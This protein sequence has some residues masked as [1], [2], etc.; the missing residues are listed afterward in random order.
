MNLKKVILLIAV[1]ALLG[2]SIFAVGAKEDVA[3]RRRLRLRSMRERIHSLK[4]HHGYMQRQ[5][6]RDGIPTSILPLLKKDL[7]GRTCGQ[8]S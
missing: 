3:N 7:D 1:A 2:T 6:C 5:N 4:M 8:N